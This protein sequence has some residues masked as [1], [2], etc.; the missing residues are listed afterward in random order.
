[1]SDIF[2]PLAAI[3]RLEIER[4]NRVLIDPFEDGTQSASRRWGLRNFKRRFHLTHA[5]LRSWEAE[6]LLGFHADRN[7]PYDTFWFRDHIFKTGSASVRFPDG[8]KLTRQGLMTGAEVILEETTPSAA[9]P[10]AQQ[11][12][13]AAG[14][15]APLLW[16][17]ANRVQY[18]KHPTGSFAAPTTTNDTTIPDQMGNYAATWQQSSGLLLP[19]LYSANDR[20]EF[21]GLE[22]AKTSSNITLAGGTTPALTMMIFR[23]FDRQGG[24]YDNEVLF[25][26]GAKSAL[27]GLGIYMTNGRNMRITDDS[28]RPSAS[29]IAA[30]VSSQEVSMPRMRPEVSVT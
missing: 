27:N 18:F 17:D 13:T 12:Y 14:D 8:F 23:Y 7:G 22:W 25:F 4:V 9:I 30:A 26:T 16:W 29:T 5:P 1:M 24:V 3:E 6:A 2:Y 10:T 11:L 19:K 21:T 20:W 15:Q 28:T